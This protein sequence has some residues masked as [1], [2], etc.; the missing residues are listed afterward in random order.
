MVNLE[1]NTGASVSAFSKRKLG[2]LSELVLCGVAEIVYPDAKN[3]P[4]MGKE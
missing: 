2:T 3:R 1:R 4:N